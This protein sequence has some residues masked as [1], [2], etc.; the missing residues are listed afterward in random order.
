MRVGLGFDAHRFGEGR[1]LVLGGVEIPFER[2]LEGH[3][4]ADVLA[5]AV[6]DAVLGA[7]GLGDIGSHFP[8]SEAAWRDA[9]SLVFLQ[10]A[11]ALVF[12]VGFSLASLDAVVVCEAPPIAPHRDDMRKW[13]ADALGC[14]ASVVS[15]KGT[16]TDRMGFTGRGEGIAAMAVVLLS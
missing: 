16:T 1:R 13:L 3:S 4:D 15:V 14:D 9:S 6:T 2:G 8:A 12:E 5:H 7:A 10:R 11:A